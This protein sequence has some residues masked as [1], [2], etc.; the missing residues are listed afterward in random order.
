MRR[1][2]RILLALML[3]AMTLPAMTYTS[4]EN[5]SDGSWSAD[6]AALLRPEEIPATTTIRYDV[7]VPA[8]AIAEEKRHSVEL[9]SS[10]GDVLNVEV[11]FELVNLPLTDSQ[12]QEVEDWVKGVV[13]SSVQS[14]R[15][16]SESLAN[17]VAEGIASQRRSAQ[18]S[19]QA[20]AVWAN[21]N[22]IVKSVSASVPYFPTLK[23][24][25]SGSATQRL[26]Q[27]LIELGFLNDRADGHF[28]DN[29]QQAVQQLE[30]YVRQLE[31][32][33][34]DTRP[35]ATPTP[36]PTPTPTPAPN[37]IPMTL[38]MPVVTAAPT[39]QPS[40]TPA[41]VVDGIADPLL[42][43]Y[44]F[45]DGFKASRQ[46]LN[47]GDTGSEVG[48]VQTRLNNLGYLADAPDGVLGGGTSRSIK[49]FQYYNGLQ[50]TGAADLATQ[51]L[52]FSGDARRPD[53]AMLSTGSTGEAVSKL[54]KRLRVLGFA[55]I[56]VDGSY[57]ASTKT[58]VE[59]LQQYLREM[60]AESILAT[61]GQ[62]ATPAQLTI[63]VNG[64]ADPLLL[65]DFYSDHFPAVPVGMNPG[66]SG[67]DVVRMQR[68][69]SMLEYY[70][71]TL[72]GQYGEGTAKAVK[73]FQK[74]HG[75]PQSGVADSGMLARLFDENAQKALKP[76]VLKVSTDDQRVYVYGLDNNNEYNDLVKTFK[77]STG[78]SG[79]PTPKGTYT[80]STG[81]GARWHYFKKFDCWAQ[82][83]YYIQGDIMFHS[84]LYG[85]KGGSVTRS[86]VNNLGRR[87]S[88]GCVRLSVDDAK[89]IWTNC[90]R[91]TK[92]IVY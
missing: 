32:D 44:L 42:Q 60:E 83:A 59:N 70:Y 67:R 1:L 76:Y 74:R 2:K 26:Q 73:D 14:V 24:G 22:L 8:G 37:I 46:A 29:T 80:N 45:S 78:R 84:V 69:L 49:I 71:G 50:Q 15:A 7:D 89:W 57:G 27:R 61:T 18:A 17:V 9:V 48:R 91:N 31:Q 68:R 40:A 20:A 21:A 47:A 72:D 13:T 19:G 58:G 12:W 34:I 23:N 25:D 65:D 90:P 39:V 54:Q 36:V 51:A 53:N 66:A 81:P 86:S 33:M 52:L 79:T 75:L 92:V 3:V 16:D 41:T 30:L 5:T 4:A 10:K 88:H 77:C 62:E 35:E 6:L 63:P 55:S 64:I 43:A 56:A 11:T 38:E 87:A 28:G 82:Y 85:S